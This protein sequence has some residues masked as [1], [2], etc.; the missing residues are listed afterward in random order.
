MLS[1]EKLEKEIYKLFSLE[2][3]L[4]HRQFDSEKLAKY[5]L[6]LCI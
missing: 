5:F 4:I 2:K 3:S 1:L 6:D